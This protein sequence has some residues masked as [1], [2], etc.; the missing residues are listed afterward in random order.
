MDEESYVRDEIRN[1]VQTFL[2]RTVGLSN[3]FSEAV[4]NHDL[5]RASPFRK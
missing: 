3:V 4:A 1:S 2:T 5:G